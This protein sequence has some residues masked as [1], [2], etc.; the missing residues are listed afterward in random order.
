MLKK[1]YLFLMIIV[2][3]FAISTVSAEDN[4]T[5]DI[6]S[7]SNDV[8]SLETN[9]NMN[10][11]VNETDTLKVSNDEVLTAGDTW[12]VNGSKTS[13]G[14]GKSES[15]AFKTLNEALTNSELQD[16]NTIMIASGEYK[17]TNNT[18]LEISKSLN[19]I[20]YGD[21]ETIFDA[22]SQSR[23]WTVTATSINITG[24]T[25]KNGKDDYGGAIIFENP[26]F[27]SNIAGT[28]INNTA[29]SS[30]GANYFYNQV[31]NSTITGTYIN[32]TAKKNS[33][34]NWF[35]QLSNSNISGTYI[36]NTTI[37][38]GAN[39]YSQVSN[40]NISGTYINNT[41]VDGGANC[42]SSKVVSNSTIT[43]TYINNTATQEG[44]ANYFYSPVSNSTISGTYINNTA[45]QNGGAIYYFQGG[46]SV[47]NCGAF[48]DNIASQG[49][50]IYF[51]SGIP[52]NLN[53]NWWGSNNPNWTNLIN[54]NYVP[55]IYAVLNVT[56]NPSEIDASGKSNITTKF[57][58]NGTNT[59]ATNL[60]PKRNVKLTTNGTLTE[61]EGDV[62]L[63]SE[64]SATTSGIYYVNATVDNEIL[65][66]NVKVNPLI[67]TN[68]TVNTTSL[69]LTIG[70]IGTIGANLNPPEA[71]NLTFTSNDKNIATIDVNGVVTAIAEGNAIITVS[72]PGSGNY[73]AAENKT[74]NVTVKL[75]DASVGVNNN[76]LNLMVND[77]FELVATTIPNG[78][79]VTYSSNNES[80]VTVDADGKVTAKSGGVAIITVSV[81]GDG[82]YALNSTN[83]TVIVHEKP[84]PPK[85]NLT[86]SATAQPIAVGENA[87]VVVTGFKNATGEVI[88]TIG[89]NKWSGEIT[90]GT[91][92]VVVT[93]LTE[94]VTA[95]VSYAGDDKYNPAST[96]VN[97]T[98]Y[99]KP[100]DNLTISASSQPITV[101]ENA[102]V[103]VTGF[104][105]ATGNVTV[106]VNGKSYAA[107][108]RNGEAKVVVPGLTESVT[109]SVNYAGDDKYNPASTTVNITVNA[110]VII[111]APDVTKYYGGSERFVVTLKDSTGNPIANA[112]INI[113]VNGQTYTK[114][115]D[116]NGET[117]IAINLNSGVYN[118]T[119]E[120]NGTKVYSTVTVKDTVI[121]KDV[122]KIYRN[123]T[124]YQGTFVD[125]KGNLVKNT[126]IRIN[127]NGVFYT[128]TT[129]ANGMAQ[130]NINLPP[131][132]YILT[133]TNPSTGEMHT[134]N[135]TVLSNIV[136]NYDLTKYYRN[137]SQYSLRLL[138]DK[139]NP[140][141]SG[142]SIQLNINGVF[143]TR[144]SD[145]N[146]YVKMNINL[147]PG[148][149]IVTA[150]YKGLRVSNT[151]NVLSVLEANDLVMKYHDGSQFKAKV[152]DGQGRPYN[153]QT[154][155]YNINGVFYTKI[156]GDD[157]VAALT[158]NLPAGEYIITS[159]Y[160]GLNVANKITISG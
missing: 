41:G 99:P 65:G 69:N 51:D 66:V 145:A 159:M 46:G 151:I 144:T 10:S 85:E 156:S 44:G 70:D 128:K 15:T 30:G 76:T 86:I 37:Y 149:Y 73:A 105:D 117:S 97:I 141:G 132:T 142:V 40:S 3:F 147:P 8:N 68:I 23:I 125:S 131:G 101:G 1:R 19:F 42:F 63:T 124:Q 16:G 91:A 120:C 107:P 25:F 110:D 34:A 54:G 57:V 98:V 148:T 123:A 56:V 114:T 78:L 152:L 108:I 22:E 64:F 52:T 138:D 36:N 157:G 32:N 50:A 130:L 118:V 96:T 102:T 6:V 143:Y 48:V 43:G 146:G 14:D 4:S 18:G 9:C 126:D 26:I 89:S 134:T 160:N 83:V 79:N 82:V 115:T 29:E 88:V 62:G 92:N 7:V 81:G 38:G 136:E 116:K 55:S 133:A 77:T 94:N 28:Y 24:L 122:T 93:G 129:D 47:T 2:C 72:F 106:T 137:A 150:E 11:I 113:T 33:G 80:I 71:G 139:G 155:I 75:R 17:G 53:Y 90:K 59:D 58:W 104:K 100:R 112:D 111:Y 12:Y 87:T 21:T 158:I 67:P 84:I 61:T 119:T 49:S 135:V 45:T 31:S 35:A 27:N 74:I 95:V 154:V 109:A 103:V 140:V 13:S 20:K 60:L 5:S 153:G 39:S 121:A 127:I